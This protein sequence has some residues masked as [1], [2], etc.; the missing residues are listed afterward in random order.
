MSHHSN[1]AARETARRRAL[2]PY[3]RLAGVLDVIRGRPGRWDARGLDY[4]L[5]YLVLGELAEV[6]TARPDLDE[7]ELWR[8]ADIHDALTDLAEL[9]DRALS[10]V[11]AR[12][13]DA[14]VLEK[15]AALRNTSGRTPA[16]AETAGK[17]AG[18]WN[19]S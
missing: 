10:L 5:R 18:R 13:E 7:A 4:D 2:P 8:I 12:L 19:A 3:P 15:I 1:K 6:I 11:Q 16:E 14:E 17:L 9:A